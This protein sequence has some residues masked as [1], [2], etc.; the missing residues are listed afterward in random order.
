MP[1]YPVQGKLRFRKE[2]FERDL[3]FIKERVGEVSKPV[4]KSIPSFYGDIEVW[5]VD[6]AATCAQWQALRPELDKRNIFV[7]LYENPVFYEEGL[8]EP[9]PP[10]QIKR[11]RVFRLLLLALALAIFATEFL[12]QPDIA[13]V[14]CFSALGLVLLMLVAAL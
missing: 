3:Q 7:T 4:L 12:L 1:D 8:D 6:F 5:W 2:S 11:K 9:E 13:V 14:L 10:R